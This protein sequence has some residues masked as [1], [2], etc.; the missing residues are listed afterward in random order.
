[1]MRFDKT[2]CYALLKK[3]KNMSMKDQRTA[4]KPRPKIILAQRKP[5][6]CIQAVFMSFQQ[7]EMQLALNGKVASQ[8]KLRKM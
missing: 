8:K 2:Y 6:S 7:T 5:F 3:S 4:K 1:M